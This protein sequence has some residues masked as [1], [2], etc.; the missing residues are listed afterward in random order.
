[1]V[2]VIV[3][4][5][6]SALFK[7][8]LSVSR[9]HFE[10]EDFSRYP[11][12]FMLGVLTAYLLA[13]NDG[14]I[15]LVIV[16]LCAGRVCKVTFLLLRM[17]KHLVLATVRITQDDCYIPSSIVSFVLVRSRDHRSRIVLFVVAIFYI[18]IFISLIMDVLPFIGY[19]LSTMDSKPS[20]MDVSSTI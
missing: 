6:S 10:V 4:S 9:D 16:T 8:S 11:I 12:A 20:G 7:P 15:R 18:R 5:V 14:K 2:I 17:L 13:S 19:R 1:M 3:L